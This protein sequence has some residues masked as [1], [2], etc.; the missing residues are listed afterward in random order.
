[1]TISCSRRCRGVICGDCNSDRWWAGRI[2]TVDRWWQS[3]LRSNSSFC[4]SSICS[5]VC[6]T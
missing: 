3:R 1:M 2:S 4:Y 5:N 6:R